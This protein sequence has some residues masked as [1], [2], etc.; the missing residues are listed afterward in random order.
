MPRPSPG[1]VSACAAYAIWGLYP[2]Y[3]HRL[4]QVPALQL[5]AHRIVWSL[6]LVLGTIAWRDCRRLVG[7]LRR[8]PS[9]LPHL[10]A[11]AALLVA[12]WWA[13]VWALTHGHVVD[14]SLGYFINPLLTVAL[15]GAVLREPLRPR[16]GAAIACAAAGVVC[17]GCAL[18]ATPWIAL[19][20]AATFAGYGVLRKTAPLGVVDGLSLELALA[21]PPAAAYLAAHADALA[22]SDWGE[23]GL[24][25]AAGPL[26][27]VPLLLFAL[28]ARRIPLAMLG[29]LQY[30]TPTL[31]L[32]LGVALYGEQVDAGRGAGFALVWLGIALYLGERRA[33]R[34]AAP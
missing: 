11:A 31:L 15:A 32:V 12:H 13:N 30:I 19:A 2:L 26:T 21:F 20:L 24:L 17:M 5:L 1:I 18:G 33:R 8:T 27:A 28:A 10:G 4:Q 22:A 16:Q 29:M 3:F 23:L 9:A 7:R 14:A 6:P 25:A 34:P